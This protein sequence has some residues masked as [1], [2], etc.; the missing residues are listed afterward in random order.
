MSEDSLSI[1]SYGKVDLNELKMHVL[2]PM[3]KPQLSLLSQKCKLT[4]N[5][6]YSS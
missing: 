2:Q 5:I 1:V 6:R 4:S 3:L